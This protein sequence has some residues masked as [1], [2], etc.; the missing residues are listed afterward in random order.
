MM[1]SATKKCIGVLLVL[2]VLAN[3]VMWV[4]Y[5]SNA[6]RKRRLSYGEE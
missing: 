4:L 5:I 1:N 2:N 3:I 6:R